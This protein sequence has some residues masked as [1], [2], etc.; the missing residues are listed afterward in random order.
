MQEVCRR[1]IQLQVY[2]ML[3]M[4]AVWCRH[5]PDIGCTNCQVVQLAIHMLLHHTARNIAPECMTGI[6]NARRQLLDSV[7]ATEIGR[8][9][10]IILNP[11]VYKHLLLV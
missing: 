2:S 7:H 1:Y 5:G 3:H 6:K 9:D 11:Y 8:R 4:H 10:P